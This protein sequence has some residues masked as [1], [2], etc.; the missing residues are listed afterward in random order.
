MIAMW[1][2]QGDNN[3]AVGLPPNIVLVQNLVNEHPQ[4]ALVEAGRVQEQ[5][6]AGVQMVHESL[7]DQ[8]VVGN[9]MRFMQ[10]PQMTLQPEGILGPNISHGLLEF[11]HT[12]SDPNARNSASPV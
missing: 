4:G 1:T 2:T 12:P 7:S 10:T 9:R 3:R 5:T 8:E 11:I 6:P